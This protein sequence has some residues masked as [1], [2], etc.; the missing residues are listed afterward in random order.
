MLEEEEEEEEEDAITYAPS[1]TTIEEALWRGGWSYNMPRKRPTEQVVQEDGLPVEKMNNVSLMAEE[2]T[3]YSKVELGTATDE[4]VERYHIIKT[5]L[6]R[7]EKEDTKPSHYKVGSDGSVTKTEKGPSAMSMFN[8]EDVGGLENAVAPEV[9]E[10]GEYKLRILSVRSGVTAEA[11]GAKDY[12]Q[13][14]LEIIGHDSAK[15]FTHF[16]FVPD[17]EKMSPKQLNQAMFFLKEFMQA[18]ELDYTRPFT[19]AEEW[20]GAEGWAFLRKQTTEGYGEQNQID[21]LIVP[22]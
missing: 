10:P 18:F 17:R 3:L 12:W 9:V 11:K 5:E 16:L 4:E 20:P 2:D 13:P 21:K 7:R 14:T 8:P 15:D 19:P 6:G 1:P 22:K